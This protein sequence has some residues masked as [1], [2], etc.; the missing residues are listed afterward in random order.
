M[1]Q[2]SELSQ[3]ELVLLEGIVASPGKQRQ[4]H[5]C[6]RISSLI[7]AGQ[8]IMTSSVVVFMCHLVIQM[9]GMYTG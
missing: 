5:D 7:V 9:D 2:E 3:E 6:K 8:F 4:I 1:P